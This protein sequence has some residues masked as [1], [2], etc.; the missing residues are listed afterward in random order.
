M[1]FTQRE[2]L[3]EPSENEPRDSP[4]ECVVYLVKTLIRTRPEAVDLGPNLR[5]VDAF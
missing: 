2:K 1:T 5:N 3:I 4:K